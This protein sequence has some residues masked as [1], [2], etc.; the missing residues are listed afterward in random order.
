MLLAAVFAVAGAAKLADLPGSR[1]AIAD[2]GVPAALAAPLGTLLPLAELAVAA[3]LIPSATAWWGAL[4][5]F[6]L[7]LLFA[8][9]ISLNLIRGRKPDCHCFGQ[10]H[11]A[12]A[13]YSTLAR[14]GLFALVAGFVLWRGSEGADPSVLGWL[15]S[16]SAG[17]LAVLS[18][19]LVV[20]GLVA[21]QW[22]FLLGLFRQNGRLLLRIEA[23]EGGLGLD[24][25]SGNGSQAGLPPGAPASAF[26]LPGLDGEEVTLDALRAPGK[27]VVLIFTDPGCGPCKAL[28]PEIAHW[29]REHAGEV[30]VALLTRGT[31]EENRSHAVERVLL[32]EDWEVAEAYGADGTPSA[33]LVHPDGTVGSAVAAGSEA[34]AALVE[35]ALAHYDVPEATKVGEPA[36][37]IIL[38]NLA[39]EDVSLADFGGENVIVLFWSPSCGFCDRMLPDLKAWEAA[40]PEGA[41]RLL[42]VSDGT[43]EAN[44]AQGLRSPVVLDQGS[45]SA[46]AFG[47]PG[48]P[49]AVL[50]DA[51]GKVASGIALGG[52]QVLA[53][54]G[55]ELTARR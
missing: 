3:A 32:Q 11:S 7:L 40:P 46:R 35:R 20:L 30:T 16:L 54:A 2:F 8:A 29:Q 36:P 4:G 50:V 1:R 12:P 10:I 21:A 17:Q 37:A 38:P 31:P 53:L 13:G 18:G 22:V 14:N 24:V 34:V 23:L 26:G 33:V 5:A 45:G 51:E 47:A 25:P 43:V 44:E 48:T 6:V 42:V 27:P 49:A 41:P 15:G 9:G 28:L 19:G 55:S 39:G 52:K